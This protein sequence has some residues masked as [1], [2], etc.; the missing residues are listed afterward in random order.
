MPDS[1]PALRG[2]DAKQDRNPYPDLSPGG[3]VT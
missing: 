3:R 2:A 1:H